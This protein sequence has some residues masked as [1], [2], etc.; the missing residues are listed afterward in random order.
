[1]RTSC[2]R[3]RSFCFR[4]SWNFSIKSFECNCA[5]WLRSSTVK[6][7]LYLLWLW[8]KSS[9]CLDNF[10]CVN[11]SNYQLI[12]WECSPED[13]SSVISRKSMT[14]LFSKSVFLGLLNWGLREDIYEQSQQEPQ[15]KWPVQGL[16]ESGVLGVRPRSLL[17]LCS[18]RIP[19]SRGNEKQ[20]RSKRRG[21]SAVVVQPGNTQPPHH[22][23]RSLQTWVF[24]MKRADTWAICVFT[25]HLKR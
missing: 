12:W 5:H 7:E 11:E 2:S 4:N 3:T 9:L 21:L 6:A 19:V 1:M 24:V 18:D 8:W 20:L 14:A 22:F 15:V 10:M 23:S 16:Q 17:L 13:S 25:L